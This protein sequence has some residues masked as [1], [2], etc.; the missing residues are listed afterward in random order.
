MELRKGLK[1]VSGRREKGTDA[2]FGFL[3]SGIALDRPLFFLSS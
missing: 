2:D 3:F 1:K